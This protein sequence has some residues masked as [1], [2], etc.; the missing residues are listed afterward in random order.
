MSSPGPRRV[1]YEIDQSRNRKPIDSSALPV[2]LKTFEVGGRGRYEGR[3]SHLRAVALQCL[4]EEEVGRH[5]LSSVML[6]RL[7]SL[8]DA[9]IRVTGEGRAYMRQLVAGVVENRE[10]LDTRIEELARRFPVH[11]LS[12]IDRNILRLAL[13]ELEREEFG[14]PVKVVITEAV[15]LAECYGSEV[16][17]RFVHGVLGAALQQESAAADLA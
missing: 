8:A 2:G 5:P 15:Q 4:Y 11:T 17:P 7:R 13:C 9:G 14:T 1:R 6:Q 16:S 3:R 12:F 10:R